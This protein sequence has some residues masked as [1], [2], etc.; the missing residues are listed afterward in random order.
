[1]RCDNKKW[2]CYNRLLVTTLDLL[3]YEKLNSYMTLCNISK[4]WIMPFRNVGS[5]LNQFAVIY[6]DRVSL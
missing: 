4:K 6:G 5:A 2:N 1:M 3:D